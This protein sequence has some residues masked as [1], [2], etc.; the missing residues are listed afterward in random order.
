MFIR[1]YAHRNTRTKVLRHC[2]EILQ[3]TIAL[4][5][6]VPGCYKLGINKTNGDVYYKS[7]DGSWQLTAS[8]TG[9]GGGS[10]ALNIETV[11][12]YADITSSTEKRFIIVTSDETNGGDRSLYMY[13]GTQL[14]FLQTLA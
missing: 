6:A 10:T 8:G 4:S 2:P 3:T 13:T 12:T 5:G 14:Q 1:E 7:S 9:G 11:A